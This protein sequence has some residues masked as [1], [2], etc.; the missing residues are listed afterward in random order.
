MTNIWR[1]H[2]LGEGGRGRRRELINTRNTKI[3]NHKD[4][5]I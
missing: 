1:R 4:N 5:K 3:Q 2:G